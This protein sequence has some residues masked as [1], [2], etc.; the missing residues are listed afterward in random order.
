MTVGPGGDVAFAARSSRASRL[1]GALLIQGDEFDVELP[2]THS[3]A[4]TNVLLAA[5]AVISAGGNP[6]AVSRALAQVTPP[7]GRLETVVQTQGITVMVDT[8]HNPGALR[9]ALTAARSRT[10]GRLFIVFG[11]GGERDR[12]KRPVMGQI[13]AQLA[14]VVVL[15]DDNPRREPASRIRAEVRA[16]CPDCIEV[17]SRRDAIVAAVNMARPGDVVLVAGKGDETVQVVGTERVPHDD[18]EVIRLALPLQA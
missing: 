7:P 10:T 2:F 16:G 9:T 12:Q 6:E 17:P 13:A 3:I 11:A 4:V 15:T 5:V 14:D 1:E 8:A 18:R